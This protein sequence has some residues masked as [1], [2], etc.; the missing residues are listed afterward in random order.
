MIQDNRLKPLLGDGQDSDEKVP[1]GLEVLRSNVSNS[2]TT[3]TVSEQDSRRHELNLL[4]TAI[5]GLRQ[6]ELH[7]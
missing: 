1:Y 4:S 6:L 3:A 7:N 2:D 5:Q